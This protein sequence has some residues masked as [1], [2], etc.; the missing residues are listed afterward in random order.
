VVILILAA[1]ISRAQPVERTLPDGS[2]QVTLSVP[3]MACASCSKAIRQKLE[4]TSGVTSV[5]FDTPQRR[6]TVTWDPKR[7]T[8]QAILEAVK[9]AGF[10]ATPVAPGGSAG[11]CCGL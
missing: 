1:G 5:R 8:L 9:E 3:K 7:T 2:R 10:D 4:A 6:A 11:S